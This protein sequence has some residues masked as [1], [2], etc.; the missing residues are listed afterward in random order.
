MAQR[1]THF[2]RP[3]RRRGSMYAMVIG[4]T[5]LITVI[6]IGALA[7][8]RVVTRGST[9]AVQWQE[10]GATAVSAAEHAI[11]KLNA[12]A[13]AAPETWRS[14]YTSGAVAFDQPF[15]TGRLKWVLVDED[16]GNIADDYADP[17][18]LYGVGQVGQ[19]L[20]VYSVQ[21]QCGGNGLA[22]LGTACH[23]VGTLTITN[24]TIALG[25]SVSTN[26]NLELNGTLRGT[27]EVAGSGG[28]SAPAKA[29]PAPSVFDLYA[30]MATR[31]SSSA[32]SSGTLSSGD[33]SAVNN[34]YGAVN[35]DGIYI[36]RLPDSLTS[37]DIASCHLKGTLLIESAPTRTNQ[38]VVFKAPS[39]LEPHRA[40]L[41]TII[42]KGIQKVYVQGSIQLYVAGPS[43]LA[44]EIR[45][46][47]HL[48]G[49]ESV[50]VE[51]AAY[52][53]GTLIC[54]GALELKDTVGLTADP[55]L[56]ASPPPGYTKGDVITPVPGSWKWDAP[57]AA[58]L[59]PGS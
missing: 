46:L 7:T 6:G 30:A 12:D 55:G 5:M 17:I 18:R 15:G 24:T 47:V 36:L 33:L 48:I 13:A 57:P 22:V 3:M 20:R 23:S 40:D 1:H 49:T 39:L 59:A 26:G 54:D 14:T 31:I 56:V 19:T 27:S 10:A 51:N 58:V 52:I 43:S 2:V 37:L 34:P 11:A 25:G 44:S 50:R 32:A 28:T 38:E 9:S 16:D 45:G 53:R 4:I 42:T 29:M 41:P 35:P 8:A 21:L